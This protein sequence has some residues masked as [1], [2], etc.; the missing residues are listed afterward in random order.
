MGEVGGWC[1]PGGSVDGRL[2]W[3]ALRPSLS[4]FPRTAKPQRGRHGDHAAATD[5]ERGPQQGAGGADAHARKRWRMGVNECGE[6]RAFF[7]FPTPADHQ[8]RPG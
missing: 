2:V 6:G 3:L 1:D 8:S 4:H 7:G 5:R